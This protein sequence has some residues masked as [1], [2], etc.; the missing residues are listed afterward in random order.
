[1]AYRVVGDV[2]VVAHSKV[3]PSNE[4][5]DEYLAY[6]HEHAKMVF[7]TL[8]MTE[9]GG[10]DPKQ[11]A[12]TTEGIKDSPVKVAVCTDAVGVRGI[13]TAL[14]WFNKRIKAFSKANVSDALT[15]LDVTPKNA[16]KVLAE[17]PKLRASIDT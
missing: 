9:G 10:P 14:S 5:W 16:E 12:K 6:Y 7:R 8:V 17:V 2:F 13:V 1:M 4:E 11:R 3:A 15:Y